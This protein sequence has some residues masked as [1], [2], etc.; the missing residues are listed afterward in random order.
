MSG[1]SIE[2]DHMQVSFDVSFL[3]TN[4]P[5][6]EA[7]QVV[8]GKLRDAGTC[9]EGPDHSLPLQGCRAAGSVPEIHAPTSPAEEPSTNNRKVQQ[10]VHLNRDIGLELS[11]YCMAALRSQEAMQDQLSSTCD[12]W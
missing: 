5:V 10:W 8:H 12:F 2:E 1:L 7:V 3:F 6:E 9:I 11:G 4:I